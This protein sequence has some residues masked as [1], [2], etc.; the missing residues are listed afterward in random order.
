M[1]VLG[2]LLKNRRAGQAGLAWNVPGLSGPETLAIDVTAI[3]R[4][5]PHL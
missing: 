5:R 1:A 2:K 4:K 3:G